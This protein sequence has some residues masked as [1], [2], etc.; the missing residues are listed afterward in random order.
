[1]ERQQKKPSVLLSP[2]LLL[3]LH[4]FS[5]HFQLLHSLPFSASPLHALVSPCARSLTVFISPFI[6]LS[7]FPQLS[8]SPSPPAAPSCIL[9][10]P[11]I[12]SG[13]AERS[14]EI[15]S[16][17]GLWRRIELGCQGFQPGRIAKLYL[18]S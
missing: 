10:F 9:H 14:V 15:R 11:F 16:V 6:I 8:V 17:T 2:S 5:I 18:I 12:L 13:R 7:H 3:I 4:A 1:M